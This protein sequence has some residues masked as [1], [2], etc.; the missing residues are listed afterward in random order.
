[1]IWGDFLLYKSPRRIY[2]KG[3]DVRED[4]FGVRS[5]RQTL[6]TA[7]GWC[8]ELSK[9]LTPGTPNDSLLSLF[10]GGMKNLAAGVP[11]N[12]A[13]ARLL[14]RWCN[15]WGVAPDIL[16]CVSCGAGLTGEPGGARLSPDGALCAACAGVGHGAVY[17]T[18]TRED[19]IILQQAA[20]LPRERFAAW[21]QDAGAKNARKYDAHRVSEW[22]RS[23]L[24]KGEF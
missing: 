24:K 20:T 9:R 21:A 17:G 18:I 13:D 14:W 6:R 22:L 3:V 11:P 7:L 10:W 1:M 8:G 19:L 12:I 23:F 16:S 2:L 5:S 4:F 15:I